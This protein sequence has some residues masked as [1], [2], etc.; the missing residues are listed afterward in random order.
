MRRVL[1]KKIINIQHCGWHLCTMS[2][3]MVFSEVLCEFYFQRLGC[4]LINGSMQC[5]VVNH[6][7]KLYFFLDPLYGNGLNYSDW[8][9]VVLI[10]KIN[11]FKIFLIF[12]M[13][14]YSFISIYKYISIIYKRNLLYLL[15]KSVKR[16][17]KP[18]ANTLKMEP[19]SLFSSC[20]TYPSRKT[21][22]CKISAYYTHKHVLPNKTWNNRSTKNIIN[23]KKPS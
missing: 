6:N 22:A 4:G 16:R 23:I 2:S 3:L 9:G 5:C 20:N 11:S 1:V 15:S 17:S 18:N 14:I 12:C 19:I 8:I 10:Y 13:F 7:I 21:I